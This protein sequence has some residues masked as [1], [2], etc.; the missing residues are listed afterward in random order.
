M[1]EGIAYQNKDILMKIL[2]RNYPKTSFRAYG[3]DLPPVKA[4]LPTDLPD[5]KANELR[6]DGV[7][8]LEDG[9]L[10]IVDYES[11]ASR[12]QLLKYGHYAFRVLE[13][14]WQTEKQL[15]D[16]NIAVIY[17]GEVESAPAS[18]HRGGLRIDVR[19]VFLNKFDGDAII[20]D[21]EE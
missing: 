20:R 8:L 21:A 18:L 10:L 12:E 7:F 5:I 11:T 13:R 1:P 4:M 3:L 19:Q 2:S 15:P 14:H 16:I 17:T 9:S 6:T